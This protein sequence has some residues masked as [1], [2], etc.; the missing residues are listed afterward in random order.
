MLVVVGGRGGW[1]WD[2]GKGR[3]LVALVVVMVTKLVMGVGGGCWQRWGWDGR[4]DCYNDGS[5][6]SGGDIEGKSSASKSTPVG[7]S[8]LFPYLPIV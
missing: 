3:I 7:P 4:G 5:F 1:W 6:V 8:P 2:G